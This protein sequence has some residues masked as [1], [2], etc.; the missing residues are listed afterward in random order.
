MS[1]RID[2]EGDLLDR[3]LI[4]QSLLEHE[5]RLKSI[6]QKVNLIIKELSILEVVFEENREAGTSLRIGSKD[7][8]TTSESVVYFQKLL[9]MLEILGKTNNSEGIS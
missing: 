8:I 9:K 4:I 7:R 3:L 5:K 1:R 2:I 6:E